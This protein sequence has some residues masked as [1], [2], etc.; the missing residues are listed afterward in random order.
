MEKLGVLKT[1]FEKINEVR[2]IWRN[3]CFFLSI[4]I[5]RNGCHISVIFVLLL[6]V[7]M[8]RKL[9]H[10]GKVKRSSFL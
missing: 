4:T 5:L 3:C 9:V 8:F 10:S 7:F 1:T 2:C 6:L